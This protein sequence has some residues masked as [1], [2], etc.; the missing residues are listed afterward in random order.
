MA[1]VAMTQIK[2]PNCG[3]SKF[4]VQ[5]GVYKCTICDAVFKDDE[6]A[7]IEKMMEEQAQ[8]YIGTLRFRLR[9]E[10]NREIVDLEQIKKIADE[11]LNRGNN[12]EEKDVVASFYIEFARRFENRDLYKKF[13]ASLASDFQIKPFQAK[14]IAKTM[15]RFY[16][17]YVKDEIKSFMVATGV[18]D[19][20][21]NDYNNAVNSHDAEYNIKLATTH[22]DVLVICD[23]SDYAEAENIVYFLESKGLRCWFKPRNFDD[24]TPDKE[25]FMKQ[26]V[27]S[28]DKALFI[29]SENALKNPDLAFLRYIVE[30]SQ[31]KREVCY[32]VVLSEEKDDIPQDKFCEKAIVCRPEEGLKKVIDAL[33]KDGRKEKALKN[34]LDRITKMLKGKLFQQA[35]DAINEWFIDNDVKS[36]DEEFFLREMLLQA[37]IGLHKEDEEI[38]QDNVKKIKALCSSDKAIG[39]DKLEELEA[40]YPILI[41][42]SELR[43]EA[44]KLLSENKVED[45]LSCLAKAT[46]TGDREAY[47]TLGDLYFRGKV[48][49]KDINKAI[50]YYECAASKG[51]AE[52]CRVLGFLYEAGRFIPKDEKKAFEY[53][54]NGAKAGQSFCCFKAAEYYANENFSEYSKKDAFK[55]YKEAAQKQELKAVTPLGLCYKYGKGTTANLANAKKCFEYAAAKNNDPDAKRELFG[56]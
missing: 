15:I 22:R 37:H 43:K 56:H 25:E 28:T 31:S 40:K 18:Y 30:Q 50:S 32:R 42:S 48:V 54:L 2:C 34:K 13:I 23:E 12:V 49:T 17:F 9:E 4:E 53:Y 26:V 11:I 1:N 45:A 6:A 24:K 35:E 3:E 55:W 7:Q 39:D 20:L 47:Y 29:N 46:K 33:K 36:K 51:H 44:T 5:G 21:K 27:N 16:E 19:S 41:D 38:C 14:Q 8:N 52:A 10:A